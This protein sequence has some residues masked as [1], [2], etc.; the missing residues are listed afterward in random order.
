MIPDIT[1]NWKSIYTNTLRA[2]KDIKIQNFQ[3]KY[4]M[5]IIPNNNSLLKC[6]LVNSALCD[7]CTMDIETNTHT[8]WECIYVQQ[9]WRD[10]VNF[11]HEFHIDI[12]LSL[13]TI[14]FGITHVIGRLDTQVKNF[15][16]M[17]G[18]YSIKINIRKRFHQLNI[19]S[20]T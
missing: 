12:L 2:I 13:L 6:K 8:F 7:F 1:L 15:I 17:A 3:Y 14:T 9:F 10:L 20:L 16:I 4:L 11:L 18:N 5:C 19:L